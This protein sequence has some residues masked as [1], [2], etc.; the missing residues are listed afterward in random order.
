MPNV[1]Y[2]MNNRLA[3][4]YRFTKATINGNTIDYTYPIAFSKNTYDEF[5]LGKYEANIDKNDKYLVFSAR[6]TGQNFLTVILYDIENNTVLLT[7][8]MTNIPWYK[9]DIQGNFIVNSSGSNQ[10]FDWVSISPLGTYIL[11]NWQDEPNN[12]NEGIRASIYQY[13]KSMNFIRK[14]ADHANHGDMGLDAS[15][16][17]VY[18]QFGFGNDRNN[19]SNRAIWSYPLDGTS[20]I[21]LLPS[22]YNGGH[23]SCRNTNLKNWCYLSTSAEGYKEVFAVKLDGSAVVNRFAQTHFTSDSLHGDGAN[24]SVSPDGKKVLFYSNWREVNGIWDTYHV[25]FK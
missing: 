2:G 14:L 13:D 20:R 21:Q 16:K 24:V 3:N 18:V 7:K 17:E 6:K 15:S 23:I 11:I 1:F 25:E 12:A 19:V 10:I 4:T 22:K 8:D 5:L 9:E